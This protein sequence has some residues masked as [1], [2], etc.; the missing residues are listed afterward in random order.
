[1]HTTDTKT[2]AALAATRLVVVSAVVGGS[3]PQLL[4]S[5]CHQ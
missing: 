1:M 4:V 3:K 5:V 2:K